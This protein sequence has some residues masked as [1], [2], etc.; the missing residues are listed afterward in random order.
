MTSIDPR[1]SGVARGLSGSDG[2][3]AVV[4]GSEAARINDVDVSAVRALRDTA[5]AASATATTRWKVTT[6][7]AQGCDDQTHRFSGDEEGE[8]DPT[9]QEQLLGV[10]NACLLLG[11]RI[12]CALDRLQLD[13]IEVTTTGET[14]LRSLVGLPTPDPGL[15]NISVGIV[16]EA[17]AGEGRLR[18]LAREALEASPVLSTLRRT[19]DLSSEI[20]IRG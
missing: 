2:D 18:R 1:L 9:P 6:R 5:F 7:W 20:V 8:G 13:M 12:R 15:R 3:E 4:D 17:Q 11:L 14:D 19:V 16:I 10:V